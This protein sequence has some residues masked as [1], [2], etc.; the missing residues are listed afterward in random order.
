MSPLAQLCDI[1]PGKFSHAALPN[2][3]PLQYRHW[4]REPLL[5][6]HQQLWGTKKNE[7][8]GREQQPE[9]TQNQVNSPKTQMG[10][11]AS[12]SNAQRAGK[13]PPEAT[14]TAMG[15]STQKLTIDFDFTRMRTGVIPETHPSS[16]PQWPMQGASISEHQSLPLR[17]KLPD[18]E[19]PWKDIVE[20]EIDTTAIKEQVGP[21]PVAQ[22]LPPWKTGAIRPRQKLRH[23][24]Q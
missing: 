3:C 12:L 17:L 19:N 10:T 9:T 11:D 1:R 13:W 15:Q 20:R 22:A 24:Q 5:Y 4:F 2:H 6:R 16:I 14:T 23:R 18:E 7:S 8:S 21:K